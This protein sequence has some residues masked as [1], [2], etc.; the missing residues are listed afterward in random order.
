MGFNLR[1][2]AMGTRAHVL[3]RG[4]EPRLATLAME[5]I[6]E[7]DARWS[8]FRPASEV[9]ALN[10]A[11][12]VARPVSA[13]TLELVERSLQAW[14]L[15]CGRFDPALHAA[16]V[17]AGY[18]R[19]LGELA[20]APGEASH[21]PA[22]I[23]ADSGGPQLRVD[24]AA[25]TAAAG[26]GGLD[27][28][29]LGKGLAAD[30]VVRDLLASGAGGA[31]VSLGGD[32]R[33]GGEAP[34]AGWLI[35]LDDPYDPEALPLGKLRLDAGAVATSSQLVRR[36]FQG[37]QERHH[38]LDPR[39]GAPARSDVA[40]V[41]VLTDAGWQAEALATAAFL[42]GAA[43]AL[44]L[45]AAQ[46]ATGVVCALDGRVHV[47]PDLDGRLTLR[48][49]L[50]RRTERPAAVRLHAGDRRMTVRLPA[51]RAAA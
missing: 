40:A 2:E 36:W 6:A 19:D 34:A 43:G 22:P 5:R 47:G 42:A 50:R 18:D 10:A 3:V 9:S 46:G 20:T 17:A 41:T 21:P 45:L 49:D 4:G 38:L 12:G 48:G 1:C 24:R 39:T 29:G 13:D 35:D 7:L 28:G 8:R 15:T 31:L 32:L 27:S 51:G 25:G 14:E 11:P 30:L 23:P 33:C 37:T 44:D 26:P 16:I